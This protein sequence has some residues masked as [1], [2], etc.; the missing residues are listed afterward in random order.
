[1]T[2]KAFDEQ[3]VMNAVESI[4]RSLNEQLRTSIMNAVNGMVTGQLDVL[5]NVF[6]SQ[7]LDVNNDNGKLQVKLKDTT[8]VDLDMSKL[9]GDMEQSENNVD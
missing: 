5:K 2:K 1:M 3:Q 6:N 4:T 7:F 9:I 8:I